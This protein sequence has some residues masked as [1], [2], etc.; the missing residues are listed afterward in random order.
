[1]LPIAVMENWRPVG[2]PIWRSSA[3]ASFLITRFSFESHKI[4]MRR[5]MTNRQRIPLIAWDAIVAKA[6]P[7][8]PHFATTMKKRSRKILSTAENARKMNGVR[9]SPTARRILDK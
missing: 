3:I 1:M 7:A 2:S 9:L 6:A 8:H 4:F 5:I